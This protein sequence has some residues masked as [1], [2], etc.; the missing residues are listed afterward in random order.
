MPRADDIL[1]EAREWIKTP[2]RH[3]GALK[4]VGCDCVGLIKGVG[5]A[6]GAI[7]NVDNRWEKYRHYRRTPNPRQM[8]AGME[9]FLIQITAEQA[10]PGDIVWMEWRENLPM[11]LG[12]IGV[13]DDRRTLIH[14]FRRVRMVTE[15]GLT[16]EWVD[17]INSYW[18]YP[19]LEI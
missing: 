4:G 3:Q 9:D 15:H 12:I 13:I 5:Q 17:M 2:F 14:A 1:A 8:R 7:N 6:T 19:Y 10:M 11:H 16:R 18:R